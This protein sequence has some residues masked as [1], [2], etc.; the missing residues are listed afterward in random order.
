MAEVPDQP[1]EPA[2]PAN[3][4]VSR[5]T[6]IALAWFPRDQWALAV[7]RWPDLLDDMPLD[8]LGYS[9]HI[10]AR[11]KAF[12]L[13]SGGQPLWV[14]PLDVGELVEREGAAAGTAE[15]RARAAAEVLRAGRALRWP[16]GRNDACWCRSGSKYKKCCRPT[17]PPEHPA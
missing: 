5:R 13:H 16:P 4:D 3:P 7:Q 1:S 6:P 2:L 15:A 14:A 10:E 8:H 11:F 17:P 12:S 9:H